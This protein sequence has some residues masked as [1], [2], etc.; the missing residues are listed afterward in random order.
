MN[1]GNPSFRYA[2]LALAMATAAA[3]IPHPAIAQEVSGTWETATWD[4]PEHSDR[5]QLNLRVRGEDGRWD[6]GSSYDLDEFDGL[7]AAIADGSANDVTFRLVREAGTITFEGDFRRG[8]GTGTFHFLPDPRYVETM[9]SLGYRD[10]EPD[11]LLL[12]ATL[13]VTTDYVRGLADLGYADLGEKDLT[14]FAIHGVKLEY[15]RE[16]N[17]LGYVDIA[18]DDLVRMRIHG[19]TAEYVRDVMAALR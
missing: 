15:I 16:M 9:A 8:E 4:D 19:V 5:I 2:L 1:A 17:G 12:Y 18:A 10:V 6:H 3:L 11:H 7:D 13:D 14:R